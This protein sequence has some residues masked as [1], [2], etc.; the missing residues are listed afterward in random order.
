M[1]N[2]HIPSNVGT[3][4]VTALLLPLLGLLVLYVYN[5]PSSLK[6][7]R[8]RHLPP[9]P[10]G[11]PFI[12]NLLD[13]A[14]TEKVR[15]KAIEWQRNY[16]EIFYTKIGGSDYVWL[17]SPRT[18]KELM[19]KKSSVYSSRAPQPMAADTVSGGQRQLFMPYGASW[20]QLRKYSHALLNATAAIKY[21]PIQD[22]ESKQLMK[23]L[24]D[25][26]ENFYMHNRRYSASVIMKLTYGFRLPT[27][28]HPVFKRV[29]QVLDNFTNVSAPGAFMVDSF[30]SLARLPES[31]FGNW[32][33]RGRKMFEHDSRVYLDLW[34]NLKKEVDA[35]TAEECFC[36]DFY[37]NDPAKS[38]INDLQAAYTCGGLI[39]AGSETTGTTLNNFLLCMVLHP[40]AVKEAQEEIERVV[41]SNRLPVWEDEKNLPYVRALV[42]EVLRWRPV[43]KFGMPHATSE[44][45]W[46]EGYF[47]PKGSVIMLNWW[48]I[49]MDESLHEDARAFNPSRYLE[50]PLPAADYMNVSDPYQRDHFTYGA[51]RRACPGVHVAERSLFINIVRTLWGFDIEKT[52]DSA[53][54]VIEPETEM[55]PGFLSVPKPFEASIKV[56]S[57]QHEKTIREAY[58]EAQ[59]RGINFKQ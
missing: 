11:L 12:G 38:G 25:D 3:L 23:E 36:K 6:D 32:R 35:G 31:W 16:G 7:T 44:D 40:K 48:A 1:S 24:L 27:W 43:N 58:K 46:Y 42:K 33:T 51:G 20:R 47:I 39:E 8:R 15:E 54:N 17:S 57:P 5:T 13:L 50:S 41:G 30:P 37:V 34:E 4:A 45:D 26:P 22:F 10:K 53:G 56:R 18:V 2:V 59:S 9:G 14:D 21:Q 29:Y 49:H 19:D 55:Y 52:R 28:D